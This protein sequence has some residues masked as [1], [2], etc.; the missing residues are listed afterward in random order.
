MA[1]LL[2]DYG[3][4]YGYGSG[5]GYGYS[6]G[7]G[8]GDGYGDGNGYGYGDGYG[9]GYGYGDGNGSGVVLGSV[10]SHAVKLLVPWNV[11]KIGCQTMSIAEWKSKWRKVAN[12]HEVT[13][14]KLVVESLI[15]KAVARIGD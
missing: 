15:E 10:A 4:G 9:S 6:N 13:V 12:D 5:Y 1:G 3:D 8:D 11:V 2:T 14:D 7:Y